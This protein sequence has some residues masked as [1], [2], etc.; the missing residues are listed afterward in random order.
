M[1]PTLLATT[2]LQAGP[3]G[4]VVQRI[5][6]TALEAVEPAAAVERH[7]R[8]EG[9]TLLLGERSYDLNEYRRVRVIGAGKAGAPMARAAARIL[10][11]RLEGGVVVVK[12]GYTGWT[13]LAQEADSAASL[14]AGIDLLEAGHPIP[15]ERSLAAGRRVLE[16][17]D[18]SRPDDLLL[19]LISGGGSALLAAPAEGISLS[20]LQDLT[21]TLL[22][23]GA[24]INEINTLRKHLDQLKG[25]QLA[26]RAY[27]ATLLTLIL[28]DVVGDPLD[29][30][31]SGLTVPDSSTYQD[32][33]DI[34]DR[35]QIWEQ[36]PPGITARISQGSAGLSPDTPKAGDP[37]F[38]RVQNQVVGSN[39]LA[40]QAALE[41]AGR[42]GLNA[43]LLTTYLQGEARV[44]GR[45]LASIARQM[46][47]TGQ[48]LRLPACVIAGGETTVTLHGDGL[49]G[50]NQELALAAVDDLTGLDGAMLVTLA[51]D[52][53][54]GP[55]DA[56]GAVVTGRTLS[57]A[58]QAGLDPQ[59]FLNRNDAYHFFE[60]LGDLLKP[61][62]TNTNVNDLAFVFY[63]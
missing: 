60:P 26:R 20:D 34:L 58:Q 2:S 52:G 8:R 23:C 46:A 14:P 18:D 10:G 56:A 37:L 49:G 32:A 62:P 17:V 38:E 7:L 59:D 54:D 42:E 35:Y 11:E 57:R 1:D 33:R 27:P 55:T 4:E 30:I 47:A 28:S 6:A 53:G 24:T 40:A 13:G 31:A 16:F 36:V 48:P 12:E 5:L 50:R 22:G 19:C 21:A 3:W 43:L 51:T 63:F 29:V 61:G 44:A 45:M 15:D 25:G 9:D 41:Q 39:L